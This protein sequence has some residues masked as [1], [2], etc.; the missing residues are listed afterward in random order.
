MAGFRQRSRVEFSV[1]HV[2]SIPDSMMGSLIAVSV[3]VRPP[4]T[5][6][7]IANARGLINDGSPLVGRPDPYRYR[8]RRMTVLTGKTAPENDVLSIVAPP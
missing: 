6:T 1:A 8:I 4:G 5:Q 2:G 3:F 7:R